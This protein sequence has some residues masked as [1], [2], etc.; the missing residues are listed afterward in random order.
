LFLQYFLRISKETVQLALEIVIAGKE[1]SWGVC[2][3]SD[4][5][6]EQS[7]LTCIQSPFTKY[8]ILRHPASTNILLPTTCDSAYDVVAEETNIEKVSRET[9]HYLFI[10]WFASRETFNFSTVQ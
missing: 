10:L 4:V 9:G 1:G 2:P 3:D 8:F 5:P 7:T 6:E